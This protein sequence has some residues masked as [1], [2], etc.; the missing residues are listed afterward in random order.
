MSLERRSLSDASVSY[1]VRWKD[2]GRHRA[3]S[4]SRRR[5]AEA[6]DLE[7]R[8]RRQLG[9]LVDPDRGR[10]TLRTHLNTWWTRHVEPDLA[11]ATRASYLGLL[12]ANVV[13]E[14]G[15]TPIRQIT[16]ATVDALTARLRA[17]GVGVASI[18]RTLAILSSAM[19]AAV[20]WDRID[21]NPVLAARKPRPGTKRPVTAPSPAEVEAIRSRMEAR[22]ACLVSVLAYAGLRPA[23]ALA[24]RWGD[25]GEGSVLV[26]RALT[27]GVEKTTKTGRHRTVRL[28]PS[29]RRDLLAWRL[30]SGNPGDGQLVFPGRDDRPW[31]DGRYRR[32]R[33]RTFDRACAEAGLDGVTPYSLRHAFASLLVKSGL[34]V[35]EIAAQL[36][37]GPGVTLSTYGHVLESLGDGKVD[38]EQAIIA[39]RKGLGEAV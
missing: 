14:L 7:L 21:R 11:P 30:A 24:L 37:H 39:A 5:D 8:R 9:G 34:N 22:D 29:L 15:G 32:W 13:P 27:D 3:R 23:E 6:F 38:A 4:F 17:R 26:Q 35:V 31:D 2:D 1:R 19:A 10:E 12:K 33:S 28:L 25:V 18:R 36:G 20:A 16:P